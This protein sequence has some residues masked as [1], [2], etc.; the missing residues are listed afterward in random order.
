MGSLLP[1]LFHTREKMRNLI[2][3]CLLLTLSFKLSTAVKC[4]KII[5]WPG[6]NVHTNIKNIHVALETLQAAFILLTFNTF[7]FP[8]RV[9]ILHPMKCI[10][11]TTRKKVK[12]IYRMFSWDH[13]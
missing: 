3:S 6:W 8:E 11:L 10:H 5:T 4:P 1:S 2:I 9:M 12:W 7:A 13:L